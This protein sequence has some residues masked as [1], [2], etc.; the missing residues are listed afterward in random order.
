MMN[1]RKGNMF[2]FV[3]FTWNPI[4]GRCPYFCKYCYMNHIWKMTK[5]DKQIFREKYLN[6]DLGN[7][8]TIFVGD[9]TDMWAKEVP[10]EWIEK[11]L[12]KCKKH[13]NAY[14]FLTKN[15]KRY[16]EFEGKFP[17]N[18]I[19]GTTIETNRDTTNISKAP[20]TAERIV[21]MANLI[22]ERKFISIEPIMD[23]DLKEFTDDIRSILPEFIVMGADSKNSYLPEPTSTKINLFEGN[24][25]SF[26]KVIKKDNL[27]RIIG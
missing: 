8:N 3:D 19:L 6:D 25:Q 14:L 27:K 9:S 17:E 15:P 5:S 22:V 13:D 16:L 4:A 20:Y 7:G 10:S 21:I 12:E 11:V 18:A 2:D 1:P 23:F 26:T 24:L